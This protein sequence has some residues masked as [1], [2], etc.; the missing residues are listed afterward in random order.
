MTTVLLAF[1][2]VALAV[3]GMGVGVLCGRI[4]LARGCTRLAAGR[5]A[6]SACP[7]RRLWGERPVEGRAVQ[8]H[9]VKEEVS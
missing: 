5:D 2:I 1:L 8:E 3:L 4:P 9:P 7:K 6:C